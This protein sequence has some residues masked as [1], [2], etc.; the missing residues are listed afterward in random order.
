[1]DFQEHWEKVYRANK[2]SEVSWTQEIPEISLHFI[3]SFHLPKSAPIIDI[4]GGDSKLVDH[5]IKEGY[6]DLTVLD[7]SK[8]AIEKA[9]RRLGGLA[10]RIHWRVCDITNFQPT[11]KYKLWHDR[12]TF[13]FLITEKQVSSYLK[14]ASEAVDYQGFV[15]MGTFSTNGPDKCSGLEVTKYNE[16]TLAYQLNEGFEKIKCITEDHLTPFKTKQNFLFCS[17]KRK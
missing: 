13:H 15:T 12:A 16:E 5:L 17:F 3:H 7:I 14:A 11:R 10:G 2:P 4:G 9:R 1:M 6:Q 8:T